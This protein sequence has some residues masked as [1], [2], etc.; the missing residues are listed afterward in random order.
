MSLINLDLVINAVTS[1]ANPLIKEK[2]LRSETVI[3][4]LQQFN[5]DPEHPPGDFSGVY[6]Y[7]LVEY[8]VGKPKPFLELFRQEPIKQAFRKAL[9]HNNPSILLSEVDGFLDAYT[10]GEEIRSLEIDVRREVAAFAAVFIEVAKRSRTPADV[11]MSQQIGSLHKRIANIQEI[12]DRLPTLEGIRTEMARLA[13]QNYPALSPTNT[14]NQCRAMGYAPPL[15]IALAQQ[16]RGWFETLGYRLE[17]YEIWAEDYFEWI[18]NIP[19]RRSYDRILVRGVAGEV[20]LSDVMALS[21]SVNQQKTDEGWLVT[22]RRISRAARDEVKKE[23]NHRL[24]C[25]TFDELIDLDADFTGYLDWL[26]AEIKR[27]QIDTKYVPLACTKEEIDPV[28]KRRIGISRYEEEDGW[29]DGYIDLWL[30]DPAKEH[31]SILGEFG[32]GKTWFVFHYAWTA[33]QRYRDAQKRGVERPRL[34]LVITLRDFAKALNVENVLAGFFFTQHNIRI[35]SEVF[36]QLN[37]MGKLLL[38]FDGFDEMAAKVDRQ[39]MINN[40]WELAKVVVPGAK[41]ILTCRTEHFPEAKEGRALLNAELQ[42]ST[43]QLTGETPQFEVLELEKFNDEQIRQVLLYQA[44]PATVEQVMGNPQLLDLARRPVMTDLILEA[45]PEIKAGKPV[46]MSRVYL[47]AVRRKMERDIKA[48]RTFTSLADKLYFLCELSWEMLSTDQMSL[49]YRLFP[50]RIR[51]LFGSVV[52]EEKDLDHWHY[53]MMAQ[54]MLV[55]NA[56]GDYTPAHRSLLEFFVAYKFA[57]E[58]GALAGDFTELAQAQSCLDSSVAAIDY[59]WSGY[60]SRYGSREAIAPLKAFTSESL[61]KLRETFGKAPLTKAVMDLLVPMLTNSSKSLISIIEGTRG[62]SE[63]EVGYVGGNAATL[64]VKI[65]KAVLEGRDFSHAVI[66]AADFSSAS[67]RNVNFTEAN[68]I[69]SGFVKDFGAVFSVAYSSDGQFLATGDGNGIVRLWEVSIG[70]EILTCKGHTSGILSVNFSAD[71]DTFASGGYDGTIKLW[72]SHNG[73]CLKTLEGHKSSVNSVVFSPQRKIIASGSS[74]STIRLWDIHTGQCLQV[75]QGH[76]NLIRSVAFS[77]DEKI[78]ASGASDNTV[79]LWNTQTGNCLKILKE[80]TDSIYSVAFSPDGQLLASA[81]YYGTLK[82]WD[83]PTGQCKST[84]K[85]DDNR[86][87]TIAFSPD[88]KII[89]STSN[90]TIKLW[91]INT[92]KCL[93]ILKGHFN[94]V[95]SIAFSP[96]GET[97]VSSSYDKT[98][99]FWNIHTGECLRILQGYSNWINSITFSLDNKMLASADDVAIVIWNVITGESVRTLQGHTHWIQSIALNY[100]GTILASGS[101]DSTIRLWNLHTGECLKILPGHS[102]WVQSVAFSPNNQ[103]LASGSSDGTLRIWDVQDGKC[104][105]ILHPN[106]SIRSVAFSLDG[107]ILASGLAD[108]TI[109]LWNIHTGECFKTLQVG[110]NIATRSIAFSPDGQVLASGMS[111]P[112]VGLWNTATGESLK[113]LQAHTGSVLAVAFSPDGKILASAG[114]DKTVILW[115]INSGE[116]L[117]ILRGHSLWIRSVAFSSDGKIIASCSCDST[118]KLWNVETGECINTLISKRPYENMTITGVKGLTAAEIDTLK[119]LGAVE[120]GE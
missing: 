80:H 106:Y 111:N 61:D 84:L 67:L 88:S 62:K 30:D 10:L 113:Y 7:A 86:I 90:Q 118:I 74:D 12:L 6:A 110:D 22:T 93:Q 17:K 28:T 117:K 34:P 16:M 19:V 119:T 4:L 100:D 60:F 109:Q 92:N 50:E 21:Q 115:D 64:A 71:G 20:K 91:D 49:N 83:L 5:L 11:L 57:A 53:D 38:I 112:S 58:L 40:F 41:V 23:E 13:A 101:A 102:N 45:L 68:L 82:L 48:D 56:D 98:V 85:V 46:D 77:P 97:L 18:I 27:R 116:Y 42:A 87:W 114:D 59:T 69:D 94:I 8:G 76:T 37:R 29:I 99:I 107:K 51:R 33:L 43:R 63:D 65:D 1:I 103:L 89:A 15:A 73:K 105:Q 9:D 66:K 31:I 36:D 78:L 32:T 96:N 14:E 26:E 108:G 39:Q 72:D 120:H 55:R 79:R 81:D 35:N 3:K 95:R 47:Y 25:F 75:L 24:D 52:Q 104:C 2:I 70:R 44:E 54:T